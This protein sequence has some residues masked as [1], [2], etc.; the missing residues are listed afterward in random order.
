MKTLQASL[1]SLQYRKEAWR[2]SILIFHFNTIIEILSVV[3]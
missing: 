1:K 2:G 3:R